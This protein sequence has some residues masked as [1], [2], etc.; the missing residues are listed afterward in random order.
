M[1]EKLT[2][3]LKADQ[4]LAIKIYGRPLLPHS[5]RTNQFKGHTIPPIVLCL[6]AVTPICPWKLYKNLMIELP[7]VPSPLGALQPQHGSPALHGPLGGSVVAKTHRSLT[8]PPTYLH[9]YLSVIYLL[10]FK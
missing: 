1:K 2:I 7:R 8:N 10:S 4:S 5:P 9:I 3:F 6:V